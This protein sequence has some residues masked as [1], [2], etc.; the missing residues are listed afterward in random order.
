MERYVEKMSGN[1]KEIGEVKDPFLSLGKKHTRKNNSP[2]TPSNPGRERTA[3]MVTDP[4]LPEHLVL[5]VLRI[6]QRLV[7]GDVDAKEFGIPCDA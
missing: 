6:G 2:G 1:G 3:L 5:H 7:V 4:L